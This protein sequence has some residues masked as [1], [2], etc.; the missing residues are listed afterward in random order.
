MQNSSSNNF[1]NLFKVMKNDLDRFNLKELL[2]II[3]HHHDS[4]DLNVVLSQ[5][6]KILSKYQCESGFINMER[7][8]GTN[9][10]WQW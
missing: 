1:E 9:L 8:I 6:S 7:I 5:L 10:P 2:E 3:Y 4:E